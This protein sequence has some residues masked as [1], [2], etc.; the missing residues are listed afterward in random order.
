M[1]PDVGPLGWRRWLGQQWVHPASS[2]LVLEPIEEPGPISALRVM[3]QGAEI[4]TD[5]EQGRLVGTELARVTGNARWTV[6]PGHEFVGP[7]RIE[8]VRRVR[9]LALVGFV[10]PAPVDEA[11]GVV[12]G[13][14]VGHD[15]E[16]WY[17]AWSSTPNPLAANRFPYS[18]QI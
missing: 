14:A 5:P 11:D 17:G 18:S 6:E 3:D 1:G 12:E 15:P 2:G 13:N 4:G 10:E 9:S 8:R 16:P 7:V